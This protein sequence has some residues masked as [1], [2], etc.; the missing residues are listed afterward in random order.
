[1]PVGVNLKKG[2]PVA[3]TLLA[4]FVPFALLVWLHRS[5]RQ[6]SQLGRRPD[7]GQRRISPWW[8]SSFTIITC[9]LLIGVLLLL[10]LRGNNRA[11]D[12]SQ[13]AWG[14]AIAILDD[15]VGDPEIS[16][17]LGNNLAWLLGYVSQNP[18]VERIEVQP[19]A[20]G[21]AWL[22]LAAS[23]SIAVAGAAYIVHLFQQIEALA[24]L[25]DLDRDKTL[26]QLMAALS[27]LLFYP[28]VAVVVYRAQEFINQAID[29]RAARA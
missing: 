10:S 15:A 9:L 6:I 16:R 20:I 3:W 7:G 17:E 22:L 8:V 14:E 5:H 23:G 25:V 12:A 2:G 11:S 13:V 26:M 29:V 18:P 1:M 28:L 19:A 27:C 4:L 21:L 24:A